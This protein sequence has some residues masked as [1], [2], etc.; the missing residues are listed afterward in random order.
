MRINFNTMTHK[1]FVKWLRVHGACSEAR[2][3][4]SEHGHTPR[5]A[6]WQTKR[7]DWIRWFAYWALDRG[8][9]AALGSN[10]DWKS[11]RASRVRSALV[12]W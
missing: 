9:P 10:D 8:I 11:D 6:F 3:W 2:E 1:D 4:I 5:S 12:S 7:A